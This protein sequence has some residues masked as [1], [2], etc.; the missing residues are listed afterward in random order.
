MADKFTLTDSGKTQFS[1]HPE[2]QFAALCVD[3]LDLGER[4]KVFPGSPPK[5]VYCVGLVF[6][7]GEM[8]ETGRL[9][10][11]SKEFT[12]SM[13]EKASLRKFLEDWRGKT[14]TKDDLKAGIPADKLAG[15]SCL[16]TVEHK[17]SAAGRTYA[18]I[19]GVAPL[20]KQMVAQLDAEYTRAPFWDERKKSYASE[21][22]AFHVEH[23]IT[24]P[25][26]ES[27]PAALA[28]DDDSLPF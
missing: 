14:Y 5:L 11:V 22:A 12:A 20:P 27:V 8:N 16:L 13:H 2:G 21:A 28:D 25:D 4:V 24:D 17:T 18:S 6:A 1:P 7:S 26:F 9:H 3:F 10:E 19:R 23:D 15:K